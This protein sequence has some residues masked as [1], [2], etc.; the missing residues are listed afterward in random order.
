MLNRE[1]A[2]EPPSWLLLFEASIGVCKPDIRPMGAACELV[3][4][5]PALLSGLSGGGPS[6]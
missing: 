5:V 3:R 1:P 4:L 2:F 6:R